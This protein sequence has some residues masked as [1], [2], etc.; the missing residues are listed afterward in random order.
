MTKR[1]RRRRLQMIDIVPRF[2]AVP[3]SHHVR[4]AVGQIQRL[5]SEG[6]LII[7][8]DPKKLN[9]WCSSC[10]DILKHI[11]RSQ[12]QDRPDLATALRE[13]TQDFEH[14]AKRIHQMAYGA[15]VQTEDDDPAMRVLPWFEYTF[16]LTI[17]AL[18]ANYAEDKR[19][20]TT[21]ILSFDPAEGKVTTEIDYEPERPQRKY[22]HARRRN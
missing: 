3:A 1:Y 21:Y 4:N 11:S 7:G 13:F 14:V 10:N 12:Q 19:D 22:R 20:S 18:V 8:N 5:A 17:Y 15:R 2:E 16:R 6:K 9:K